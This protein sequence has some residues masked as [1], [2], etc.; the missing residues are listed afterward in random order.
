MARY[1]YPAMLLAILPFLA[2]SAPA[3]DRPTSPVDSSGPVIYANSVWPRV[4]RPADN[5]MRD[6]TVD[7]RATDD[8][9][10]NP[11]CRIVR[12]TNSQWRGWPDNDPNVEITG[13]LRLRL[14]ASQRSRYEERVYTITVRCADVIGNSTN[15]RM[16]VRVPRYE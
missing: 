5:T 9:D 4:L 14:R 1:R 8:T 10:P 7:V 16:P 15:I 13:R 11:V 2:G 12:V 3:Q 6:V